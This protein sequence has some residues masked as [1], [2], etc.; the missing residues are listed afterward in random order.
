MSKNTT[1][2][3]SLNNA[4]CIV[5]NT[6]IIV[7]TEA[8]LIDGT[9]SAAK[10]K[11]TVVIRNG[12]I[13]SIGADGSIDIPKEAKRISLEGKSLLPGWVMVNEHLYSSDRGIEFEKHS[14]YQKGHH[15]ER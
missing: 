10:E 15:L 12:R 5:E 4:N 9:G 1:V 14:P 6:P 7:F 8:R 2:S 13:S 11:Q 3:T